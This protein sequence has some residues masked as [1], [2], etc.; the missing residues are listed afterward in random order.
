MSILGIHHLGLAVKDLD[1]TT[2]FF[3]EALGYEVAREVPDY[4]A[5][6]VSNGA[7][8]ITLWQSDEGATEFDRRANVGLHHFALTVDTEESLNALFAKASEHPGVTVDFAPESLGDGP[9]KHAMVFEPGGI[10]MEFIWLP[11]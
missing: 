2:G 10:R 7:S 11:A 3:T 4:P 1:A 9:A 8:F 6:F 5:R